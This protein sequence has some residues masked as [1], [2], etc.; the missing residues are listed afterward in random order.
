MSTRPPNPPDFI[1]EIRLLPE[2]RKH[3]VSEGLGTGFR[4]AHDF[5]H[6]EDQLNDAMHFV[7]GKEF[8]PLGVLANS[9]VWLLVPERQTGRL[10]PG[11]KFNIHA[12]GE[13][14]GH[15]SVV[16]VVNNDLAKKT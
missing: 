14:V 16:E 8:L 2:Q 1:A 15:G 10:Y 12:G 11:F 9:E 7:V 4:A 13:V 3:F 6:P 5:Q